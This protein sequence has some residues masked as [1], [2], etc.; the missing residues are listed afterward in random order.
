M[1][2]HRW[3][4]EKERKIHFEP[5]EYPENI[6]SRSGRKTTCGKEG[7]TDMNMETEKR[8]REVFPAYTPMAEMPEGLD[9]ERCLE[10]YRKM[11]L[12]RQFDLSAKDLW[13]A[14]RI[15][16]LCHAYYFAEAIAV[17]ACSALREGDYTTSTH[18]GHGHALARG[19][20]P[21]RMMAE[22]FGKV[23]GCN[24]GKGG[25][26]HIADVDSG[27]LGATGIVGSGIAPAT[28]AALSAKLQK[29]GRLSLCFFG[30]GGSNQ[31]L[32]YESMNMAAAWKLPV[33]FLCECNDWAIG[34]DIHRVTGDPVIAH[35]ALGFGLP[36]IQVDGFN[37]FAVYE[38]VAQAAERA[39]A[40][41]GPTLIEA[42]YMRMLGHHVGD[43]QFYRTKEDLERISVLYEADPLS[44]LRE[45]LLDAGVDAQMLDE[46]DRAEKARVAEAVR[47]GEEDCHEPS[48]S[49]LYTDI[50]SDIIVE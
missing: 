33:I 7:E 41:E 13:R 11:V 39:R 27:M 5:D 42:K 20:D 9:L 18:R 48:L 31:G 43:D 22:L 28:G 12:I 17:G 19:A 10:M 3:M 32:F 34:T 16:G 47:F 24:K 15:R 26:M 23:E 14:G 25:S 38:A 8:I 30:D 44:R 6:R 21:G 49:E 4:N 36:G 35:R 2:L 29:N 45:F 37:V 50:F 46:I 40:G 1:Q